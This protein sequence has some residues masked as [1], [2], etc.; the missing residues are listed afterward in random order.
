MQKNR[1]HRL[2]IFILLSG[3]S[4][5]MCKQERISGN[6][7]KTYIIKPDEKIYSASIQGDIVAYCAGSR[8]GKLSDKIFY[9]KLGT[10]KSYLFRQVK[11]KNKQ[12]MPVR[13]YGKRFVW[14]EYSVGEKGEVIWKLY[15]KSI[16]ED[17]LRLIKD[18]EARPE[19][20]FPHFDIFENEIVFDYFC[21]RPNNSGKSPLYLYDSE[22]GTLKE[23]FCPGEFNVY[24]PS[25]NG[26]N[27]NEVICNLV[28]FNG[29]NNPQVRIAIYKVQQN[30]WNIPDSTISGFQPTLY[31]NKIVYKECKSPY[32][33]GRIYLYDLLTNKKTL[34]S[35]HPIGGELPQI[36][37]HYVVWESPSFD[38]IA[39]YDLLTNKNVKLDSGVVGKPY[40]KQNSLIW[41][42]ENSSKGVELNSLLF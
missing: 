23:V 40:L 13:V 38:E 41:V 36:N 5:S 31:D 21:P 2:L 19:I 27:K 20:G 30:I 39:A 24:D 8:E 15:T 9:S 7:Q 12:I 42:K 1:I 4:V 32:S 26:E 18:N 17:T 14:T 34:I 25:F 37:Q 3:V 29:N 6:K 22:R 10:G 33:Y 35:R 16:S 28:S 11:G